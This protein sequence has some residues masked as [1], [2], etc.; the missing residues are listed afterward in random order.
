MVDEFCFCATFKNMSTAITDNHGKGGEPKSL[1]KYDKPTI[2]ASGVHRMR[3]AEW[4]KVLQMNT[5]GDIP[6]E[7]VLNAILPPREFVKD[8]EHLYVEHVLSTPAT[9]VE[10]VMLSQE[11]DR[12][13]KE[14]KAR[15]TGICPI[16]QQLY[17]QTFDELIRQVAIKLAHRGLLLVRVRDEFKNYIT[18]Y[19]KLYESSLSYGM[20]KVFQGQQSKTEKRHK[21]SVLEDTCRRLEEEVEELEEEIEKKMRD[22]EIKIKK[23]EDAHS[24]EV[25]RIKQKMT[26]M[27]ENI[28]VKLEEKEKKLSGKGGPEQ[29]EED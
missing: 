26:W 8:K 19:Q 24:E 27:K 1:I 12:R 23:D 22:N 10:V 17:A 13:I 2:V 6:T 14:Q 11:L 18:S 15:D 25:D 20:R 29:D 9:R 4:N 5:D 16:R 28:A 21:I 7:D 3:K